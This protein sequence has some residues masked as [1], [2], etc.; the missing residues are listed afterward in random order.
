MHIDGNAD[1]SCVYTTFEIPGHPDEG[2]F[3][4]HISG[5]IA[6]KN[7]PEWELAVDEGIKKEAIPERK[8]WGERLTRRYAVLK[9]KKE[10]DCPERNQLHP[11]LNKWVSVTK[12]GGELV[13]TCRIVPETK[14]RPKGAGDKRGG[15]AGGDKRGAKRAAAAVDED[16]DMF[17]V[18][19]IVKFRKGIR[20]GPK[21]T[22]RIV[23]LDGAVIVEQY[24]DHQGGTAA[25]AAA[26]AAAAEDDA[27][28]AAAEDD[29][30]ELE[31]R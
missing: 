14:R 19:E 17:D 3:L 16:P 28:A 25:N 10:I 1:D 20:V 13:K 29:E 12:D 21:G 31:D 4:H 24:K 15:A 23:E 22:Y 8:D 2:R 26:A 18:D 6:L 9:W 7:F 30:D 27:A 5:P 11:E